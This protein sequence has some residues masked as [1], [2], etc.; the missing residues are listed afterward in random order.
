MKASR[1]ISGHEYALI[2]NIYSV[3][4]KEAAAVADI[5]KIIIEIE[6]EA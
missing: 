4:F 6:A 5:P 2:A 3:E 1:Q